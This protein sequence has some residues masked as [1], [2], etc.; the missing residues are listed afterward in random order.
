VGRF[1]VSKHLATVTK[2]MHALVAVLA[3]NAAYFL[4]VPHLP[5]GAR[6]VPFRMD[7]GLLL[8]FC[9]CLLAFGIVKIAV[10]KRRNDP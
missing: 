2:F 1:A 8:D 5:P 4:L 9:L 6:H 3:G 7:V 10:G